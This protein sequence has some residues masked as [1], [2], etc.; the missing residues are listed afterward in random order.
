MFSSGVSDRLTACGVMDGFSIAV[1]SLT[2]VN[3]SALIVDPRDF[4]VEGND[5]PPTAASSSDSLDESL[6]SPVKDRLTWRLVR[7]PLNRRLIG[8]EFPPTLP[9]RLLISW[10]LSGS[11]TANGC[12][13]DEVDGGFRNVEKVGSCESGRYI[14]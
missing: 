7:E 13:R 2:S 14:W 3:L 6:V 1:L 12:W 4:R 10:R 9:I 8:S 11:L 5:P